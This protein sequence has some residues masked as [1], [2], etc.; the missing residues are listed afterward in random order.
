MKK[1]LSLLLYNV[2][3][4]IAWAQSQKA[5]AYPLLTHDP[6]FSVWSFS[7]E[8]SATTTKH[9]TGTD[10]SLMGWIKVDGKVY[11]FLGN[12]SKSYQSIMTGKA[13]SNAR[14]H[15]TESQPPDD[16]KQRT[17]NDASWK[18]GT[19]PLTSHNA[20]STTIWKTKDVWT[21][22]EFQLSSDDNEDAFLKL[23][24][25]D[26]IEVYLNGQKVYEANCCASRAIYV[27]LKKEGSLKKGINILAIHVVNT[28]GPGELDADVVRE[29]KPINKPVQVATQTAVRLT[30][31]KTE[32]DFNAGGANLTVSF[33][34]PLL[35]NNLTLLARPVSYINCAIQ[36]ADEKPHN[37]QV[38]L[39]VSGALAVNDIAQQVKALKYS[40]GN[41]SVLKAGTI[42]QPVLQKRGDDVRIDWGYLYVA[43][44]KSVTTE[45][46]ISSTADALSAFQNK[47]FK[48]RQA[49]QQSP[50]LSTV[51]DY[52]TI[53]T[54]TQNKMLMVGYDDLYSVQYFGKNLR[55]W[56]KNDTSKTMEKQ[57]TAAYNEA[58]NV[59]QDC[60][61][62]DEKMHADAA[63]AGGENY[64]SLCEMAYRQAISAH[65]LVKS[66][67]GEI[68]FLSK[69]NFSNGS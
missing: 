50:V 25:D 63:A 46:F 62:F 23:R 67:Q 11:R 68:L 4:T 58:T 19:L 18:I 1:V 30:A 16:W 56:W 29:V 60:K 66:P 8:L 2:L 32:Y 38:Q 7:D 48:V 47:T 27:P 3:V 21:R 28:G 14:I 44:P 40:S 10:Q 57:L 33:I 20:S 52:G 41:L 9:W 24:Y 34:S 17:F 64:A 51:F 22:Q 59:M 65:K 26:N 35:L 15:Y 69:E 45:Q 43:A 53:G 36:T 6:Y 12:E 49:P 5:P 61:R 13:V 39:G 42:A 55:P 37:V 54:T 31:T